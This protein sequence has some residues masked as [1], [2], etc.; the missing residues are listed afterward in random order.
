M[1]K[2]HIVEFCVG[3]FILAGI[4]S[5]VILAFRVDTNIFDVQRDYKVY[6]YFSHVGGLSVKS[7][8]TIAGVT[9]GRVSEITVDMENFRAQVELSIL[10]EY[11]KIPIDSSAR[12]LTAGLLGA[13]Y[14]GLDEGAEDIYLQNGDTIE[15]TQAAISFEDI[16]GNFLFNKS[17]D[18]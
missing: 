9:I 4:A 6:A 12:I 8:I 5:S 15:F 10:E 7:P 2:Q 1:K 16:I 11:D 14:I 3:L 18:G 17:V 13:Q